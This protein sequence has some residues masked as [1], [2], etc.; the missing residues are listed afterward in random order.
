M[1]PFG[2]AL[3]VMISFIVGI[4]ILAWAVWAQAADVNLAWDANT[5]EDLAGYRV[6][7]RQVGQEYNYESPSWEGTE[8]TCTITIEGVRDY[9]FVARAFDEDGNESDNSNEIRK[10]QG[11]GAP[12]LLR[13]LE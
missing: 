1:T 11:P 7:H 2:K 9:Q 12:C 4:M 10:A 13:F 6:F 8:I 3:I 5:E